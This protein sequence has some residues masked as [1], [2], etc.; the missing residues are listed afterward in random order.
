MERDKVTDIV[1]TKTVH[2][3]KV[4]LR[5]ERSMENNS[6]CLSQQEICSSDSSIRIRDEDMEFSTPRQIKLEVC[7]KETTALKDMLKWY[8]K[9]LGQVIK[10]DLFTQESSSLKLSRCVG[11]DSIFSL[12]Q[13]HVRSSLVN[14]RTISRSVVESTTVTKEATRGN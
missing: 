4:F 9:F 13:A 8:R 14:L 11:K 6:Y 2:F 1:G 3:I 7:G 12:A 10:S 5:M